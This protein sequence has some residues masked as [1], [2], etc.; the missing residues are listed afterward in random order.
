MIFF[1]N[2][3]LNNNLHFNMWEACFKQNTKYISLVTT[4]E[5]LL[6]LLAW[7]KVITCD[8]RQDSYLPQLSTADQTLHSLLNKNWRKLL[9][10]RQ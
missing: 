3:L 9:C 1:K 10:G 6:L 2:T 7:E 8:M 5:G 4:Y